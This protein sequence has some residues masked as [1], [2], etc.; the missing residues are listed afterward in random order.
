MPKS[1]FVFY[2]LKNRL[3]N[4]IF[5]MGFIF[6][7]MGYSLWHPLGVFLNMTEEESYSIFYICI[8][9][10]FFFYT[11]AYYLTKYDSW[12]FFPMFV[13]LV[14]LSR[15]FVELSPYEDQAQH[16]L[17]EYGMF[18]VTIFIVV[19]YWLR[20]KYDKYIKDEKSNSD[21]NNT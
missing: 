5:M 11:F 1:N 2:L 20:H 21:N 9:V 18:V 12:R 16:D 14:C 4:L 19:I 6:A 3:E 13:Y 10:S 15:V 7:I 17:I 8:A